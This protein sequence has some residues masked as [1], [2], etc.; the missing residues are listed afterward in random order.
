MMTVDPNHPMVFEID[1]NGLVEGVKGGHAWVMD[2]YGDIHQKV[3]DGKGIHGMG[4]NFWA[5]N[6]MGEYAVGARFLRVNDWCYMSGWSWINYWP[7]FLQGMNHDLHA[8][9]P[10]DHQDRKDGVDGWGSPIVQFTQRSFSPYLIQDLDILNQ[11]PGEPRLHP[12]G[13]IEWPYQTT[14]AVYGQPIE[15]NVEVFNGGLSGNKITLAWSTHWDSPTGPVAVEGGAIACEIE[16]G[17]HATEKIMFTVPN[18]PSIG[19]V[20]RRLYLVMESHK[21]GQVVFR[22]DSTWINIFEHLANSTATF[23]GEDDKTGGDWQ[24]KY[25]SDGYEL[26]EHESKMPAYAKLEWKSGATH[27]Y[28]KATDDPRALAYFANPPT[29]RD[30][31]AA[32]RYGDSV[33][34]VSFTLDVGS[35]PRRLTLYCL[36]YDKQKRKQSVEITNAMT[37]QLLDKREIADFVQGRY[38]SWRIQ[39]SVRVTLRHISGPNATISGVFL[40]PL[41]PAD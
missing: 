9:K 25:G 20:P 16:P 17:F 10:Q 24:G 6:S 30:R 39:E 5:R 14:A 29:G 41:G 19:Q 11:N 22:E 12:D 28:D 36:D 35:T 7:N 23:L 37:G 38:Q 4:E 34:E 40:D 32:S 13:K 33:D 26:I 18:Q 15:R 8:W 27:V 1:H 21:E 2:H 31:I 3:G